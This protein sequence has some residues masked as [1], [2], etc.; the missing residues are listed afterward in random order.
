MHFSLVPS[1]ALAV[2]PSFRVAIDGQANGGFVAESWGQFQQVSISP[3]RPDGIVVSNNNRLFATDGLGQQE[4]GSV[5]YKKFDLLDR[6]L[7]F[8]VD[9]SGVSCGCNGAVYLVEMGAPNQY[10]SGYCDIQ[11]FDSAP[12][13]EIDLL[14]GNVK[15]VQATLHT[16]NGRGRDGESCNADGCV[17]HLGREGTRLYGPQAAEGIDSRLPFT[18]SATFSETLEADGNLGATYDVTLT[19][20]DG[21]RT[22]HFFNPASAAGSHSTTGR[23]VPVPSGDRVRMRTAL[24]NKMTLVLS[25]WTADDL[26]WLDGG[27]DAVHS[28]EEWH[29]AFPKC[30]LATARLAVSNLRTSAIPPPPHPPPSPHPSPPPPPPSPLSPP[31]PLHPPP[32]APPQLLSTSSAANGLLVLAVLACIVFAAYRRMHPKMPPTRPM[33]PVDARDLEDDED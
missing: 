29:D 16:T 11:G 2:V 14:E 33:K 17:A 24:A 9:L 1:L 3:S 26:S 20:N 5:A 30:D 8:D 15:A 4:W 19:Q 6:E 10:N 27:C 21:A 28:R 22:V 7:S 13:L 25:L 31:P 23:P 18:V 12:C 32:P